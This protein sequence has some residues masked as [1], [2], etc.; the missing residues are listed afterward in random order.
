MQKAITTFTF[1]LFVSLG[2]VQAQASLQKTCRCLSIYRDYEL[3]CQ[4]INRQHAPYPPSFGY[5]ISA[6][7]KED[8][9]LEITERRGGFY[10]NYLL[11]LWNVL[12]FEKK[13]DSLYYETSFIIQLQ[14]SIRVEKQ[15]AGNPVKYTK[16]P[17]VSFTLASD[18][19]IEKTELLLN[20]ICRDNDRRRK[21]EEAK[22]TK[23]IYK[24]YLRKN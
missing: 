17:Q 1:S 13:T 18:Y 12:S 23:T 3:L 24:S 22:K 7:T 16:Q 19:L 2:Y 5:H 4:T 11:P 6:Q 21:L 20:K 14:D 15:L 10:Q 8:Y 9:L